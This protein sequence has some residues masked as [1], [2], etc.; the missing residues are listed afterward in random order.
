MIVLRS[1]QETISLF[2]CFFFFNNLIHTLGRASTPHYFN[3]EISAPY[4]GYSNLEQ[5]FGD[6]Y[7]PNLRLVNHV[8][9]KFQVA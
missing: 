6:T 1:Q 7:V 8:R 4:S 9:F 3:N 5:I 2:V